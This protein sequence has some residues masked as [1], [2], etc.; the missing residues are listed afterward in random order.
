LCWSRILPIPAKTLQ[1]LIDYAKAQK[2]GLTMAST[3][4]GTPQ[5]LAGE[6]F[7]AKTGSQLVHVPYKG[8]TP[9]LTDLMGGQVQIAFV[10]LSAALPYIK[11]G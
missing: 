2:N 9:M 5:H 11:T 6:L 10:T 1:E 7:K 4:N 8:D 3:G